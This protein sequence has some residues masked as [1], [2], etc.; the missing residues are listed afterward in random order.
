MQWYE[1]AK[2]LMKKKGVTVSQL[3]KTLDHTQGSMSLKL[4]GKR[5]STV[6]EIMEIA[7]ILDVSVSYLCQGD[8]TAISSDA[9]LR[10]INLM[11]DMTD[12]ER[13]L[14]IRLIEN[15]K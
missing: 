5:A 3:A 7:E 11:R 2:V 12:K 14:V 8:S 9:E 15:I 1:R 13:E 4:T 10:V 6:D